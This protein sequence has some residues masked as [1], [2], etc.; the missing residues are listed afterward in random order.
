MP[1]LR[2]LLYAAVAIVALA[3]VTSWIAQRG[4]RKFGEP[5]EVAS[6]EPAAEQPLQVQP[7]RGAGTVGARAGSLGAVAAPGEYKNRASQSGDA[8]AFERYG[9]APRPAPKPD[10]ES[11]STD[12]QPEGDDAPAELA[13]SGRGVEDVPP[14][15]PGRDP[16]DSETAQENGAPPVFAPGSPPSFDPS[17]PSP[18]VPATRN[19]SPSHETPSD[20]GEAVTA[21]GPLTPEQIDDIVEQKLAGLPDD[22]AEA[23][24]PIVREQVEGDGE[25][26]YGW[27][28]P[29][30]D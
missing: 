6:V 9:R 27:T 21:D 12:A 26:V 22:Q 1:P 19:D 16:R 24:E 29:K 14:P 20:S 15:T 7:R 18:E 8:E 5:V 28:T 13:W 3:A 4:P 25:K 10:I 23:L 30:T 11:R 2:R 17:A